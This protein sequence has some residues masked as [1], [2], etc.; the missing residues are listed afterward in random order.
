MRS[1]CIHVP[2]DKASLWP[3]QRINPACTERLRRI[4][5]QAGDRTSITMRLSE[6]L[7]DAL[8]QIESVADVLPPSKTVA[9][10]R[11]ACG[12]YSGTEFHQDMQAVILERLATLE[13]WR[14]AA[15]LR[16]AETPA[17]YQAPPRKPKKG[18]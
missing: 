13:A 16:V 7:S 2:T 5:E 1:R 6:L 10:L 3:K 9:H 18:S 11:E 4:L 8:D 17:I 14:D 12:R 15:D